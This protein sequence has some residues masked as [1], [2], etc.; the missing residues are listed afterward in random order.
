MA[1][2]LSWSDPLPGPHPT[3]LYTIVTHMK[4]RDGEYVCI[5][6]TTFRWEGKRYR[7]QQ[8]LNQIG[9]Y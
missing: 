6:D 4:N 3:T 7:V 1:S 5:K 2:K 9:G 8:Q